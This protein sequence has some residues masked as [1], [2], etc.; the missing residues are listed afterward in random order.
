MLTTRKTFLILAVFLISITG[1]RLTVLHFEKTIKHPYAKKG[2]LDLRGW[3]I[4]ESSTITLDGEWEFYPSTMV[5]SGKPS[6]LTKKKYI[7]VPG[8]WDKAFPNNQRKSFQYGTYRLQ[9]LLDKN[10]RQHLEL[11]INEI[12]SASAIYINGHLSAKIGSP[13][14]KEGI[15]EARS[16]P[17]SIPLPTGT[18][19]IE[20]LIQA[21]NNGEKGG[22]T[23]SLHFGTIEA[24]TNRT[25][26][27]IGLQILLCGVF[28]VHGAYAILFYF[29]GKY[30]KGMLYF[31]LTMVCATFSV[32][33]ADDKLL[34]V[35]FPM[36]YEISI[37]IALLSYIGIAAFLPLLV[38]HMFP[39][40]KNKKV[41]LWFEVYCII[42][43]LFVLGSPSQY[44]IPSEK[45]FLGGVLIIGIILSGSILKFAFKQS[46]DVI[47]LLLGCLSLATNIIWIIISDIGSFE[48]M[49]YPFDLMFSV[50]A[51]ATFWFKRFL[52]STD[53]TK[54]LADKL[55]LV[56][57]HK[58]DFL[59]NTSHE[60]RNPLHGIMNIAQ[61]MLDETKPQE[62]KYQWE[63]I[64]TQLTIARRMSLMLDDLIDINRLNQ[65]T[66]HLQIGRVYL[67]SIVKGVTEMVR[68]MFEKKPISL[69]TD[70]DEDFPAIK[71]DENRLIQI[72]FN[73]L[74]NAMK[75][76]EEGTITIRASFESETAYIYVADT[77][78]GMD[79]EIQKRIFLPYEQGKLNKTNPDGGFGLGLSICKQLVELQGGI[80]QVNSAPNQGS[81]F[82]FTIPLD[83]NEPHIDEKKWLAM[84]QIETAAAIADQIQD[85]PV[86]ESLSNVNKSKILAVD[87]DYI[88]LK[89][90]TNI[91]GI[92]YDITAVTSASEAMSILKTKQYDLIISD[93]MMPH[94]S[95]YE[96]TQYIRK[97]FSV[98]ELP[99]LLLTAR[100]R[101]EDILAGFQSGANDY[102]TKPVDSIELKSRVKALIDLKQSI[103]ER[104]H[105][106]AAWLQAQIKPHFLI[107]TINSIAALGYYDMDK[108]QRLLEEFTNYM[109]A[110][111]D[112]H[113]INGEVFIEKE[114]EL[115]RSYLFIE[116]ERFGERIQANW[117]L[118]DHLNFYLPP[119]SLQ[120]LVENAVNHGILQR[121]H[122]GEISIKI[123][124]TVNE[125]EI[126]VKDNG[127]GIEQEKI[128]VLLQNPLNPSNGIGLRNTNRR[129]KQ[130]Y[131][132]GLKIKSSV[133]NGTTVS[134][135]IPR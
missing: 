134:F 133:G 127:V 124:E 7:Q 57:Q 38:K 112:F 105:M 85:T 30:Q 16:V 114:L 77:G 5:T 17:Y 90:L 91:L 15:N 67:Q 89:V 78:I 4:P 74:H 10:V 71:A 22:I 65:G 115:V 88:N 84:T 107:N 93:V 27:S 52:R 11:R 34:F 132:K 56:N 14:N 43:S 122:G 117:E 123:T 40:Y 66:I 129:L 103:T 45:V 110:S 1:L 119:L 130:M 3:K 62:N 83:T 125:I 23:K 21:S 111:F 94:I 116:K 49:H 126:T 51:L 79:E 26:I 61:S 72:L 75:Y 76:T 87:D 8:K 24:V 19:N 37:K 101:T 53:Q 32:L 54:E 25:L 29:I 100:N 113:N 86:A 68:F 120:T 135:K 64:K 35:W 108:M 92:N 80:I 42:Y 13:S 48:M 131:G 99:V 31:A 28:L 121:S 6:I 33:V 69:I 20:I 12:R 55:H 73:L 2:T 81:I 50:I 70:I 18:N 39:E 106:E 104:L 41:L 58:D 82:T 63:K 95:G 97:Q 59:V 9:I 36:P 109:R 102:V 98:S 44:I 128:A 47:Y 46:Q 96:L 60:L 118:S